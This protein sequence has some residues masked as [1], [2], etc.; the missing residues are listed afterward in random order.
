MG[1]WELGSHIILL[2]PPKHGSSGSPSS[3]SS[4]QDEASPETHQVSGHVLLPHI[5]SDRST[6]PVLWPN[7]LLV[8]LSR[9]GE[10]LC[11]LSEVY[12]VCQLVL[13]N[14]LPGYRA[15]ERE[16]LNGF[17]INY[18]N[19]HAIYKLDGVAPFMTDPPSS[20]SITLQNP[21]FCPSLVWA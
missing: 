4:S 9:V 15:K 11:L 10:S 20:N 5:V 2:P 13:R 16:S 12:Q 19:I 21:R 6:G 7:L 1:T 3:W 18:N 14:H 8:G 17:N